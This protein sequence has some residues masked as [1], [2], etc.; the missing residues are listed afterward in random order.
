VY[1][2]TFKDEINEQC[3]IFFP[4]YSAPFFIAWLPYLRLDSLLVPDYPFIAYLRFGLTAVG[5]LALVLR[6]TWK[7]PQR[8]RLIG[9][10]MMYYL[11]VVAGLITG[12][13]KAHPS[14][15]GGYCF[16][17]C[18]LGAMPVQ[19]SQLYAALACSLS[20]FA[21]LCRHFAVDFSS[22]A[23]Q[24]SLQDL[25]SAVSVSV[26]MSFGWT[27]LR[28][29]S[30]EKGKS[31]QE[32]NAHIQRQQELL[33]SQNASLRQ[34]NEEKDDIIGIV[35]HDL[36]NPLTSILGMTE[37]LRNEEE[38][39]SPELR[40]QMQQRVY[41]SALQMR[42]LIDHLLNANAIENGALKP[43]IGYAHVGDI[44]VSVLRGMQ[45]QAAKK[46][47]TLRFESEFI[48]NKIDENKILENEFLENGS[49]ERNAAPIARA[50]S[51]FLKQILDNLVSN[52]I[53]YSPPRT[54]VAVRITGARDVIRVSVKDEG[55]GLTEEDF[56]KVFQKFAQLS[57]QPTAGEHSA[58]LGLSIV[59]KMTESMG[60]RVWCESESGNGALFVVE[61]PRLQNDADKALA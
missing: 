55:P 25:I 51:L 13:S 26:L 50:D 34:L 20:V 18:I 54:N 10:G 39:L 5:I 32:K 61:L 49:V 46:D 7:N 40:S 33:E 43:D 45:E 24:Y 15:V 35:S 4:L 28:R 47:I 29:N 48:E 6:Y 14:Y 12:L 8:H 23:L 21:A 41:D 3:D 38:H 1:P 36:R 11:I 9:N 52:A 27:I 44:A 60:G 58:G 22:P 57:A 19:P 42:G 16:L 31:L 30:Y 17:I 59:K 53:K 2:D 37:I 56:A